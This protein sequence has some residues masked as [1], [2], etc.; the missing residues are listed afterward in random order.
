M[1]AK[2]GLINLI[3]KKIHDKEI[4]EINQ[5]LDKTIEIKECEYTKI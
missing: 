5:Q 4:E 1:E 2:I 3:L